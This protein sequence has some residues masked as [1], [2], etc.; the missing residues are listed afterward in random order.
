MLIARGQNIG[1]LKSLVE[2]SED[3]E[4]RDEAPGG[5]SG[6]SHICINAWLAGHWGGRRVA[7]T[8]SNASELLVRAL[9][10]ISRGYDWWYVATSLAVAVGSRHGSHGSDLAVVVDRGRWQRFCR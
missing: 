3:V 5:V 1:A 2:V 9:G 8:S 6:T 4:Y 7:L 10:D